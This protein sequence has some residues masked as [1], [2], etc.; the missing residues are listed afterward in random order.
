MI[1]TFVSSRIPRTTRF[2]CLNVQIS[3]AVKWRCVMRIFQA[4][5]LT[6][7][8][9]VLPAFRS[10]VER[11]SFLVIFYLGGSLC[12]PEGQKNSLK[13]GNV[14]YLLLVFFFFFWI[15]YISLHFPTQLGGLPVPWLPWLPIY[16]WNGALQALEW[17]GSPP[18]PDP[19]HPQGERHADAP[20]GLLRDDRIEEESSRLWANRRE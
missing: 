15:K 20:Q 16:L 10:P 11:E 6:D 1:L 14:N 4:S 7:S 18:P 3:R 17:L 12:W 2:A 19:V 9:T 13:I 5:G 8:R